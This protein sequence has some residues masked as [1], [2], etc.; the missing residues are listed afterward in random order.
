MNLR[1][2]YFLDLG[3]N[4]SRD[5]IGAHRGRNIALNPNAAF[6][7]GTNEDR[8]LSKQKANGFFDHGIERRNHGGN[9]RARNILLIHAVQGQNL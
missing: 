5:Q 7:S 2:G 6:D 1:K 4:G 3:G 9:D 8:I